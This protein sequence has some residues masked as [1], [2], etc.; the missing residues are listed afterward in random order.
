[1]SVL[2]TGGAGFVAANLI[3]RLLGLGI[4]I[5]AVDNL[6]RGS[7]ANIKRFESCDKFTFRCVDISD[8]NSYRAVIKSILNEHEISKVWHLAAN[9]DIP[10]GVKDA[11]VD[12][13]DTFM[14]T[15]NTLKIMEEFGFKHI[16]FASSSAVYGDMGSILLT[17]DVGPLLPISNYGAMKLASE[18]AISA[19]SEKFLL[20][21]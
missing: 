15:V 5:V 1:V 18:A 3:E 9:S 4:D 16:L 2:V 17:E 14:S 21:S 13:K 20:T 11:G 8:I 10:A 12:L 19:A 7:M 6:S